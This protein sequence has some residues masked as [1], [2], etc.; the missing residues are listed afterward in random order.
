[1]TYGGKRLEVNVC[2]YRMSIPYM[3]KTEEALKVFYS[4]VIRVTCTAHILNRVTENDVNQLIKNIKI[5][6]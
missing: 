4:N 5:I 6:L 2:F 3:A 1:M